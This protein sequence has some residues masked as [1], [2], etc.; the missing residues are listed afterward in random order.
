MV[1]RIKLPQDQFIPVPGESTD[2]F[3]KSLTFLNDD[4]R[5]ILEVETIKILS[6]CADPLISGSPVTGLVVGYV[7]S[8]KTLSFTTLIS[9][10]NDN[11][12]KF[13]IVLAGV[14]NN[15]LSQTYNRLKKDLDLTNRISRK[16]FKIFNNP[17]KD[18]DYS[19]IK[20]SHLEEDNRTIIITVLKHYKHIKELQD[21]FSSLKS[22][23]KN[24]SCLII[25]DEADQYSLNGK[26][27]SNF[28]KELEEETA[29]YASIINLRKS[30]VVHSYIQ[31]TATPQGPMLIAMNDML[32]PEFCEILTP[33][34]KYT[35]GLAFFNENTIDLVVHVPDKDIFIKK[36]NELVSRPDSLNNAI[37][38][39]LVSSSC[40]TVL[41]CSLPFTSML[42]HPG[43]E[44]VIISKYYNWVFDFISKLKVLIKINDHADVDYHFLINNISDAMSRLRII[45]YTIDE[46]LNGIKEIL[47]DIKIYEVIKGKY[48]QIDWSEN[49]LNIL[50]GGEMLNRG[51]TVE[52]LI[53]TY[54]TRKS[55]AKSN[56]DTLQ[57][58]ARF[59][60]YKRDYLKYCRV[61]LPS[62]T[63]DDFF[64]YV[65]HEESFRKKLKD[66][67]LEQFLKNSLFEIGDNMELTRK[68]I[69]SGY[70]YNIKLDGWV[71]FSSWK[72]GYPAVWTREIIDDLLRN[73][74]SP[75]EYY[76]YNNRDG[77]HAVFV[78]S[79]LEIFELIYYMNVVESKLRVYQ[80]I[81]I[82][83][84]LADYLAN[85]KEFELVIMNYDQYLLGLGRSRRVSDNENGSLSVDLA[86]GRN[87]NYLGDDNIFNS[88]Y[89]I[90]VQVHSVSPKLETEADL[91]FFS[92]VR[93]NNKYNF[94]TV[95]DDVDY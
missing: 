39:Y 6:Q 51:Y 11:N 88:K 62:E 21:I 30:I 77:V 91:L 38:D 57:Q 63:R 47:I 37:W 17:K 29:T 8:G 19:E 25:D 74:R 73:S 69:L 22:V 81:A 18:F 14:A 92:A 44:N 68:S 90:T 24:L 2:R 80:K 65:K 1:E 13:V 48:T 43:R 67:S 60:G 70:Y 3:L 41:D 42:I 16:N 27:F 56:S 95:Y 55:K 9:L 85:E 52:N 23:S 28:K 93:V 76:S 58:R 45:D 49:T 75:T 40:L 78:I 20:E 72:T 59:F 83:Q 50:V 15:L 86:V 79:Y 71:K 34:N 66:T 33:G 7:Q 94:K 5:K 35:G 32:K 54:L 64:S 10:A 84:V 26:G 53:T 89:P 4:S 87:S 36:D 82:L 61:Y 31:Y 12:Y 46:V